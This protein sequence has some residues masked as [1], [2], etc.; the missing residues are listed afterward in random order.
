MTATTEPS[1]GEF[2]P[3]ATLVTS[4][5]AAERAWHPLEPFEGVDYK[6]LWRS[7]KS[8][9]GLMRVAP[10]GSVSLHA[11]VRAHHHMW[12]IDGS[13][14]MLGDRVGP[15]TYLHI[16]AGVEH[17]I[18]GVGEEGCTVLYL[19]LRDESASGR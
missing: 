9:A 4:A 11:H 3:A 1:A 15:G 16:P 2:P 10:G 6:L 13:A 8:V 18:H 17:G 12:V 5:A 14:N 19:Y 7:G